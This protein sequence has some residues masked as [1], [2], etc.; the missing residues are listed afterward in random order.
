MLIFFTK[1]PR[2]GFGKTRLSAILPAE[3]CL[4]LAR[5]LISDTFKVARHFEVVVYYDGEPA[6]LEFLFSAHHSG[7]ETG[8]LPAHTSANGLAS[9]FGHISECVLG[10]VSRCVSKRVFEQ[11]PARLYVSGSCR[12]SEH[13]AACPSTQRPQLYPQR[14]ATLG[15]RMQHALCQQLSHH[16]KVILIGSDIVGLTPKL[17]DRAYKAL[18]THDIVITPTLDG[19][20]G[21]I[22][23]RKSC[24]VF[25]G[26]RFSQDDVARNTVKCARERGYSITME[27]TLLDVDTFDDALRAETAA[28]DVRC[29]GAGEYNS[30][31]LIERPWSTVHQERDNAPNSVPL[32]LSPAP[33]LGAIEAPFVLRVNR[34][35][36]INLGHKQIR[37]EFNAL[38]FLEPSGV[39]PRVYSCTEQ[40]KYIPFGMLTMEYLPGRSLQ[41]ERDLLLAAHLLARVHTLDATDAPLLRPRYPQRA[42]LEE[43]KRMWN[44]YERFALPVSA[45]SGADCHDAAHCDVASCDASGRNAS[46][47]N[48]ATRNASD[49][50]ASCSVPEGRSM[51]NRHCDRSTAERLALIQSWMKIAAHNAIDTPCARPCVINTEL[52]SGNFI[53]ND[54]APQTLSRII[55]WEKPVIADCEQDIAH[56]LVPTT[57]NWKTD[58]ILSAAEIRAFLDEYA[59]FRTVDTQLLRTYMQLNVLRGITWCA[60]AFVQYSHGEGARNVDT[61]KKIQEF[62][63]IEYLTALHDRFFGASCAF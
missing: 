44:V 51:G 45:G 19:G 52:N 15:E 47:R 14:G 4:H 37:Y 28:R 33:W 34:A 56:F 24:D 50:N 30:N 38:R 53:I 11:A 60:M 55:D 13:A 5:L 16:R 1:A 40:G 46:A 17:I 2:I 21:L 6:D 58:T 48:A 35:S 22:G 25:S 49:S 18:D 54:E 27:G 62:L 63:S 57:T 42:L 23:M 41:Y 3:R 10:D 26:M 59:R 43:C 7:G 29:I 32:A 39:T 8:N 31:F 20:Y 9:D 12:A 61:W 36:Q